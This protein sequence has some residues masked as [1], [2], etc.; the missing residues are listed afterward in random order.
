MNVSTRRMLRFVPALLLVLV[1]I[2]GCAPAAQLTDDAAAASAV[3][4]DDETVAAASVPGIP[5]ASVADVVARVKPSVVAITTEMTTRDF[6]N[7]LRTQE[8][9]GSGWIIRG[10]GYIVTNHHVV[11]DAETVTVVLDDG[12]TFQAEEVLVDPITDL[13]VVKI[14][15]TGL[16]VAEVGD[17]SSIRVGDPLV[18]IGNSLGMG[19][20]ATSGIASAV[21]V[22]LDE[23]SGATVL[24][25]VQT[26]AAINPGNSGGPLVNAAGE[27]I[28]INSIKIAT[29][30]VEGMGYA[31]TINQALPIIQELIENKM[32]ERAWLGVGLYSITPAR[33]EQYGLSMESGVILTQVVAGSPAEEA[34]L[35]LGDIIVGFDGEEVFDAQG[36]ADAI[37]AHQPGDEVEITYWRD[38]AKA[39]T[40]A[41]L[42]SSV[43]T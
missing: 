20:S 2:A 23:S 43:R 26:D 1:L 35:Q 10:D 6:F 16:P 33:A 15:E 30:G 38:D 27:V 34:G 24:D 7:R 19:I 21:G 4:A 36:F 11:Q 39:V 25:L 41:T 9:A 3:S 12:R 29:V 14:D 8:S 13:A 40:Y 22:S 42:G 18:A 37:E 17:V 31:I 5:L 28:G 32:V